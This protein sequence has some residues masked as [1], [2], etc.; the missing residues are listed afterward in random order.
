MQLC[1]LTHGLGVPEQHHV[2][3]S[4]MDIEK[5]RSA[6]QSY[7]DWREII[8]ENEIK[9]EKPRFI[10]IISRLESRKGQLD[11]LQIFKKLISVHKD[12]VLLLVGNGE[13]YQKIYSEIIKLGLNERVILTGR[14][15]DVEQ[16]I[17]LSEVC[18][19]SSKREGLPRVLIQYLAVNRPILT[20]ECEGLENLIEHERNAYIVKEIKS[21][22]TIYYLDK[23]LS[24]Q[25]LRKRMVG[26]NANLDLEKWN[27]K[28][29]ANEL[30]QI[31]NSLL[32]EKQIILA[33]QL[34]Q[35]ELS[36][37]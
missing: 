19:L 31:Y 24:S 1:C 9:I 26:N 5:F 25:E 13:D 35:K 10:T 34:K 21:K 27:T 14:R 32:I 22:D 3:K 37:S 36:T 28:T 30:D 20:T 2:V 17:S 16:I 6:G 4:G 15:D 11:F 18:I 33:N 29:M 23:L 12:I 7:Y 8:E